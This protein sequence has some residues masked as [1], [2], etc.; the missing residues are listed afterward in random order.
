[1]PYLNDAETYWQRHLDEDASYG[2][3]MFGW[4]N[5]AM[6]STV[7]LFKLTG[8]QR[9]AKYMEELMET[10]LR[11]GKNV[12]YTQKVGIRAGRACVNVCAGRKC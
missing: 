10:W 2:D 6:P 11:N 1:M 4:D 8:E 5:V 9:Y 7:L 3:W 12:Q